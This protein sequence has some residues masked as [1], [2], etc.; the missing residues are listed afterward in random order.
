MHKRSLANPTLMII[1][2]YNFAHIIL[3][4]N[5]KLPYLIYSQKATKIYY[6]LLA[7]CQEY[8]YIV[9]HEATNP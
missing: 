2:S 1:K 9:T 4:P 3:T 8:I 6:K 5:K 7:L